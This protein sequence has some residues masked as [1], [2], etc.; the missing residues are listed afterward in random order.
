MGAHLTGNAGKLAE[1]AYVGI[2]GGVISSW[3]P[4]VRWSLEELI[5]LEASASLGDHVAGEL[6]LIWDAANGLTEW[7]EASR[8]GREFE[9]ETDARIFVNGQYLEQM[10]RQLSALEKRQ[11]ADQALWE[12]LSGAGR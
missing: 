2:K 6:A 8:R 10:R 7:T 12:K 4:A 3:R 5:E 9:A 11:E 1:F